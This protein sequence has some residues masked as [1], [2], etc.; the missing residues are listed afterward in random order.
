ML[1][2]G[3]A[4]GMQ[5]NEVRALR[6]IVVEMGKRVERMLAD[7]VRAYDERDAALARETIASDDAVNA[8][9]READR[10]CLRM[11]VRHQPVAS[12]ARLVTMALKIVSDFERLGDIHVNVAERALELAAQPAW[13]SGVPIGA[14]ALFVRRM[15]TGTVE[16]FDSGD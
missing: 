15:I 8:L 9:E 12:D 1:Q 7:A 6:A 16:A 10:A 2:R 5:S 3:S 13:D 14:M 11:L 4:S